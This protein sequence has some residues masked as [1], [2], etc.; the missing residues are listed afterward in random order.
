[1]ATGPMTKMSIADFRSINL[2][3][4][5]IGIAGG[6]VFAQTTAPKA[7]T[8]QSTP[9]LVQQGLPTPSPSIVVATPASNQVGQSSA[10]TGGKSDWTPALA[11]I[12][13]AA[14][15][16]LAALL[17]EKRSWQRRKLEQVRE[18]QLAKITSVARQLHSFTSVL[19]KV[20]KQCI[21]PDTS[22]QSLSHEPGLWQAQ[23]RV[24]IL[25][26]I[27]SM[28]AVLDEVEMMS[29]ELLTLRTKK[30]VTTDLDAYLSK[31][32][33]VVGQIKA[34]AQSGDAAN[35]CQAVG[36]ISRNADLGDAFRCFV[37]HALDGLNE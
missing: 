15:G 32:R 37:A 25:A 14:L 11:T 29:I 28:D 26:S 21:S 4:V 7:G 8:K 34:A 16:F 12:V 9:N 36:A 2:L 33:G 3:L 30:E 17:V 5:L 27:P 22:I 24:A 18:A 13:A 1:M 10:T 23:A 35:V 6:I 31:A 19:G 20:E